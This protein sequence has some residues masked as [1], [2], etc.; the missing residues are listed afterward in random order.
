MTDQASRF[1]GSIPENYDRYL[2]P[3]IFQRF[4]GDLA[5]RAAEH[6]PDSVLELAAGTGIVSRCLRD[7]LPPS[8]TLISTDLN[9]PMLEVAKSKFE[10]GEDA[11]FEIA[12]A[13]GL[14][15]EDNRFD[16]V[17]CQFGV[18]FFPD[19]QRSYEEVLRVLQPDGRYLF[20]VWGS[21]AANPFARITHEAIAALFPDD[22]PGFYKVPFSYHEVDV[23]ETS[24]LAAG[25]SRVTT[26]RVEFVSDIP[27]AREFAT[28]LVFGNPLF[29][30][31][32]SRGGDPD[33]VCL[34]V[35]SAIKEKLGNSMP[36]QATV[37][38]ALAGT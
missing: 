22:P 14:P 20:N 9:L 12:D 34:A 3:R 28:G 27:S 33:H 38:D 4:A 19:K 32:T 18:M 10:A 7:Q 23:I 2:G 29:E 24:L 26:H 37:I 35:T 8:S 25:F 31:V 13:T 30:E 5:S 6:G 15:Y 11:H 21:L 36:L 1:V 17:V 16:M